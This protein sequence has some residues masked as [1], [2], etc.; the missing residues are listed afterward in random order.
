V[1][2]I[3]SNGQVWSFLK[4]TQTGDLLQARLFTTDDLPELLG[5]LDH[6]CAQCAA[7]ARAIAASAGAG[8]R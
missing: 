1:F 3:T 6:V 7:A 8:V 5:A 4:L 2:G